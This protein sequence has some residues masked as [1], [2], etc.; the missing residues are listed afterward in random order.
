MRFQPRCAACALPRP[1][2]TSQALTMHAAKPQSFVQKARALRLPA[3]A[4]RGIES[5]TRELA[6]KA[7][8]GGAPD[9]R[10]KARLME[11]AKELMSEYSARIGG[12]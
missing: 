8:G 3:R 12:G 2:A 5:K 1:R 10:R 7:A 6:D 11:A 4:L 9:G